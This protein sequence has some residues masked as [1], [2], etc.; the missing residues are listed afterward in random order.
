MV[1]WLCSI[2]LSQ[3][4]CCNAHWRDSGLSYIAQALVAHLPS[5]LPPLAVAIYQAIC[6]LI[7]SDC[8]A[9]LAN[10]TNMCAVPLGWYHS[11]CPLLQNTL[12][13]TAFKVSDPKLCL[14]YT[15]TFFPNFNPVLWSQFP[16]Y[17]FNI[18]LLLFAI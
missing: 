18:P 15:R 17:I 11:C 12:I 2:P 1:H 3:F 14:Y 9:T 7:N 16:K 6:V 5:M 10:D 13:F 8:R 4:L